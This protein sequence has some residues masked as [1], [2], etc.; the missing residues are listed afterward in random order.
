LTLDRRDPPLGWDKSV[1]L[2]RV[3][4][5]EEPRFCRWCR[6]P[7]ERRSGPGRPAEYC[8]PSHR[9]RDY[10]ARL[11]SSE[12][13]LAETDLVVARRAIDSLHDQIYLLECA[14]QDITQD[15]AEDDSPTAL[16]AAL[17][18]LLESARSLLAN[19]PLNE[20]G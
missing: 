2:S 8:R 1:H 16:R 14:I 17:D 6:R 9:Q 3:A 5:A 12:L 18:W 11:R 10:E 15:L 4:K 20:P 13:G 7:I 19:R